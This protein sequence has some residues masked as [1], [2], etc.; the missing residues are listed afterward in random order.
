MKKYFILVI[1]RKKKYKLKLD[2][3]LIEMTEDSIITR[4]IRFL[5][6]KKQK[7]YLREF[8]TNPNSKEW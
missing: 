7:D 2:R 5:Y 4:K 8:K 1:F 6:R 3:N